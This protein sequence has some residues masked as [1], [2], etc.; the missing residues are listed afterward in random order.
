[1][2]SSKLIRINLNV[3]TYYLI[4]EFIAMFSCTMIVEEMIRIPPP[5]PQ[6]AE[7]STVTE[8]TRS[9]GCIP[10]HSAWPFIIFI[11]GKSNNPSL[12]VSS[13]REWLE[14]NISSDVAFYMATARFE[15]SKHQ[16]YLSNFKRL[17][18]INRFAEETN[19]NITITFTKDD[20]IIKEMLTSRSKL[21][22]KIWEWW[23]F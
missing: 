3:V 13:R 15:I 2:L 16:I 22:K 9:P 12:I 11:P 14:S 21:S 18:K 17:Q 5:L 7:S 19:C 1:M 6:P 10:T 23:W 4:H 20:H 8:R